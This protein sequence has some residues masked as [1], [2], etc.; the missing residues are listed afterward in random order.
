M[1]VKVRYEKQAWFEVGDWGIW[2]WLRL[3]IN[4]YRQVTRFLR[5]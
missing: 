1:V 5:L 3:I 2:Y 4:S